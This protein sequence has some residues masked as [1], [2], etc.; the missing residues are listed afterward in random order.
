MYIYI[1]LY[2]IKLFPSRIKCSIPYTIEQIN[3][4]RVK[5]TTMFQELRVSCKLLYN[6][7]LDHYSVN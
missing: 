7:Q 1:H 2:T 6:L 5:Y 3:R 4:I